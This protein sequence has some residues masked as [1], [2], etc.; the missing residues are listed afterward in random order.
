M[1]IT[2]SPSTQEDDQYVIRIPPL[3]ST[4]PTY[5]E[6]GTQYEGDADRL[7]NDHEKLIEQILEQEEEMING[8]RKHIDEV[9]DLVKNE[10]S[11]LNEVDKPGS[12][13]E[14]FISGLDKLLISKIHMILDMRKQIIDFH[15]NLKTEEIMSK[16]Y[17][18]Q[19]D[20]NDFEMPEGGDVGGANNDYGDEDQV[21]Q[22]EQPQMDEYGNEEMLLNDDDVQEGYGDEDGNYF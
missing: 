7:C 13:V 8:H 1:Q 12:D 17:Q 18:Q 10:M 5:E 3:G 16:L 21:M 2:K 6:L 9:V 20:A 19:Q 22:Q 14:E 11:L 15:T 4:V